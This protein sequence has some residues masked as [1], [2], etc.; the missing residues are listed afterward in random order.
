MKF[1]IRNCQYYI[2]ASLVIAFMGCN[3]SKQNSVEKERFSAT[4]IIMNNGI[5]EFTDGSGKTLR[6][7]KSSEPIHDFLWVDSSAVMFTAKK[8]GNLLVNKYNPQEDSVYK[9]SEI[10]SK[11]ESAEY[12]ESDDYHGMFIK[13]GKLYI[14]CDFFQEIPMSYSAKKVTEV[15]LLTGQYSVMS[16]NMVNYNEFEAAS[17]MEKAFDNQKPK[18]KFEV[19]NNT[20]LAYTDESGLKKVITSTPFAKESK[21]FGGGI[22]YQTLPN[23]NTII[24]YVVTAVGDY[25]HGPVYAVKLDGSSQT[26]LSDDLMGFRS[27][28]TYPDGK[29]YYTEGSALYILSDNNSPQKLR[30][31]ITKVR[32]FGTHIFLRFNN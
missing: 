27:F 30:E 2:F 19:T 25:L 13:D 15:D 29:V 26:K 7:V 16:R 21:D 11:S 32:C 31:K 8:D 12:W 20:E 18:G 9:I 24:F 22:G 3:S 14:E 4:L 5:L 17:N 10:Q 1:L 28:A 23:G 6:T